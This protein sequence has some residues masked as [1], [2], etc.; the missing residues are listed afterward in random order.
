MGH[1]RTANFQVQIQCEKNQ[2]VYVITGA[3]T[4]K[5]TLKLIQDLCKHYGT[6][7]GY[8]WPQTAY[9]R[10]ILKGEMYKEVYVNKVI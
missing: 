10:Q 1:T 8:I 3:N 9:G 2:E 6:N 4:Y 7:K 5:E